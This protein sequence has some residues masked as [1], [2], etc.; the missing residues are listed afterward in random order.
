MNLAVR[1]DD[2]QCSLKPLWYHLATKIHHPCSTLYESMITMYFLVFS[3][4]RCQESW[5]PFNSIWCG[6]HC[7]YV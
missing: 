5:R 6:W 4:P 3:S 7:W 1:C 2:V